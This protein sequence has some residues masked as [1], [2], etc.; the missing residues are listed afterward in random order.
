[1]SG[2]GI[3]VAALQVVR[4]GEVVAMIL[5]QCECGWRERFAEVTTA[6]AITGAAERHRAAAA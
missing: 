3:A 4:A 1:V 2:H 6:D 5:M